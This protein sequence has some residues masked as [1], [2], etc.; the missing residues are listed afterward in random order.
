M[1]AFLGQARIVDDQ[2]GV[3]AADEPIR[4]PGQFLLNQA[5]VPNPSEMK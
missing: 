1:L 3:G 2:K 5:G 4:L